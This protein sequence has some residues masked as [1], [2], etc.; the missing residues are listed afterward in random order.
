MNERYGSDTKKESREARDRVVAEASRRL[1]RTRDERARLTRT[2]GFKEDEETS[3]QRGVVG[4]NQRK[5]SISG[6]IAS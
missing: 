4:G 2:E 5:A 1:A 6:N 3:V